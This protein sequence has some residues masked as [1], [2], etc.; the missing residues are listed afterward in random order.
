M[1]GELAYGGGVEF[2]NNKGYYVP[3]QTMLQT[4]T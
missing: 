2:Y 4:V 3:A 1:G